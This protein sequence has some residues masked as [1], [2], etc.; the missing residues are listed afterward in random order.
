METLDDSAI[1]PAEPMDDSKYDLLAPYPARKLKT[2]VVRRPSTKAIAPTPSPWTIQSTTPARPCPGGEA[3]D[4]AE[5]V[6]TLDDSAMAPSS[7]MDDSKY[8]SGGP[9]RAGEAEDLPRCGDPRRFLIAPGPQTLKVRLVL[10]PVRARRRL[11]RIRGD[12]RRFRGRP[13]PSPWTIQ[14]TTPC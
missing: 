3:E 11:C 9:V 7:H 4:F 13:R 6:E 8:D 14:S 5:F 1:S 12:P 10:M 2:F